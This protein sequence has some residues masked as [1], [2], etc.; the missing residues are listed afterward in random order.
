MMMT[1]MLTPKAE[2]L[3]ALEALGLRCRVDAEALGAQAQDPAFDQFDGVFGFDCFNGSLILCR[4]VGLVLCYFDS[5]FDSL[6]RVFD[7]LSA[8][9]I[10]PVT[11]IKAFN[12]FSIGLGHFHRIIDTLCVWLQDLEHWSAVVA[13]V[14]EAARGSQGVLV[15]CADGFRATSVALACFLVLHGLDEAIRAKPGQ[16][17]MTAGEAVEVH[18]WNRNPQPQPQPQIFIIQCS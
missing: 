7:T 2:H 9:Q 12:S 18:R 17:R 10:R 4:L 5:V 16:P 14:A 13:R 1:L 6:N 3:P 8:R 15:H 11:S